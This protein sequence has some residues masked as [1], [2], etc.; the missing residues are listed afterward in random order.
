[1]MI[2][3][4]DQSIHFQILN[5]TRNPASC[6]INRF[7]EKHNNL[8]IEEGK[9]LDLSIT[10][11]GKKKKKIFSMIKN[12][13]SYLSNI[14]LYFYLCCNLLSKI[15]YGNILYRLS[16]AKKSKQTNKKRKTN[17][18]TK[19]KTKQKQNKQNK[20]QINKSLT[21]LQMDL[22]AD[23]SLNLSIFFSFFFQIQ[24]LISIFEFSISKLFK[25]VQT[26]LVLVQWFFK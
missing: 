21:P 22:T 1:M 5:N 8:I 17:K 24:G 15:N 3:H 14:L 10:T 16:M 7:W 19:K 13:M 20:N 25:W 4:I 12:P 9:L 6:K 2:Y 26:S 18:Q 23:D 11:A